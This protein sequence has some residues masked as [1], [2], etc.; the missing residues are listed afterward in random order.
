M[1]SHA[2]MGRSY[3]IHFTSQQAKHSS[4]NKPLTM[5]VLQRHHAGGVYKKAVSTC[6]EANWIRL[7]AA[8]ASVWGRGQVCCGYARCMR[9][10]L[11][12]V[13]GRYA[14][15][16]PTDWWAP[17]DAAGGA[18]WTRG[19]LAR[20]PQ[21]APP[22]SIRARFKSNLQKRLIL[23]T[24]TVADW[25]PYGL[26]LMRFSTPSHI[27]SSIGHFMRSYVIVCGV[28]GFAYLYIHRLS[29]LCQCASLL[30]Q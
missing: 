18:Q 8:N 15:C 16:E 13:G 3:H 24:E 10:T 30:R 26:C 20:A 27:K 19:R 25:P 2:S 23:F 28:R 11:T 4:N 7:G 21:W 17:S 14:H 5:M 12:R 9:H 22:T 6:W 29:V 1:I